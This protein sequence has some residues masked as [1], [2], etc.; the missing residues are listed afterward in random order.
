M[1]MPQTG[2]DDKA[3]TTKVDDEK[4]QSQWTGIERLPTFERINTALF[5]RRD[6]QGK[7]RETLQV[8][9]V[10]KLENLDRH[11][12]IDDLIKHVENDNLLL[13]QKIKKRIDE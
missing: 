3:E 1:K 6:E 10:S 5:C 4:L 7:R 2:G 11:L 13:L 8:M 12:F 9:D